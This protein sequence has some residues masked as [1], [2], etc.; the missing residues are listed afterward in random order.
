[1]RS[2]SATAR[3]RGLPPTLRGMLW[4][5]ASGMLFAILNTAMKWLALDL[6]PW[7][8]GSL[9]Y[10]FGFLVLLP[11][12]WHVG[13]P[14]LTTRAPGLTVLRCLF[15]SGGLMLWFA[16]LPM[17]SMAEMTALGFT[18]PIFM[19]LGAVL[20]LGERMSWAR[21]AAVLVG[22][23]GVLVVVRPWEGGGFAGVTAGNLL[24]LLSSPVFAASFITAKL[25]TRRDSAE[26]IVLWQHLGVGLMT[27][28]LA[29]IYW[30]PPTLAQWLWM[31]VCGALGTAG[32]Y[33][34]NRAFK[35]TDVSVTQ[36]VRFLDLVWASHGGFLVFSAVP[37][38]WT[39]VGAAVIFAS[40][41]WLA[42]HE[43][44]LAARAARRR[45]PQEAAMVAA[46]PAR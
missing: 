29:V 46:K 26:T 30:S 27:L 16:A 1:L 13:V 32:H 40:T 11:L 44:R 7:V 34:V 39:L 2:P 28:P 4:M 15:H 6:H 18:G 10:F 5:A 25:L 9:R 37:E 20:A 38:A 14:A 41:L 8:V 22:F 17:V 35:A 36:P 19:C 24:M 12:I 21:W 42:R 45:Q 3:L 33:C 31:V 43:A 23:V